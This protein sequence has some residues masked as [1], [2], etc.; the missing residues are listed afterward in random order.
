MNRMEE[1]VMTASEQL[2]IWIFTFAYSISWLVV[3][4][5]TIFIVTFTIYYFTGFHFFKW[6]VK[7]F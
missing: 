5:I 6:F 4:A 2:G 3:L 7:K 1:Q